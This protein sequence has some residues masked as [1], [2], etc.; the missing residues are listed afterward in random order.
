MRFDLEI[1][2]VFDRPAGVDSMDVLPETH[3]VERYKT[4]QSNEAFALNAAQAR[5]S[6]SVCVFRVSNDFFAGYSIPHNLR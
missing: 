5:V 2:K 1:F 6:L 3:L 4:H